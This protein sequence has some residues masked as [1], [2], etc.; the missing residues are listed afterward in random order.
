MRAERFRIVLDRSDLG[1]HAVLVALE[2]DD[3]VTT[4]YAAALVADG[5]ATV[6]V[7]T[8]LLGQGLEERLLGLGARDLG[9][10]RRPS[11]NAYR[12]WSA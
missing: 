2:V 5:D 7:A 1:G 9:E 6:V 3:A 8:G 10:I 4:L 11:A 12:R